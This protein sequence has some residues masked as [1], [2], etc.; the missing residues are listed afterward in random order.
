MIKTKVTVKA[1]DNKT[2][3][4]VDIE[5]NDYADAF[6]LQEVNYLKR[7]KTKFPAFTGTDLEWD[8]ILRTAESIK[9]ENL[10]K[11]KK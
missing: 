6:S 4:S 5:S 8:E 3:I 1:A 11:A 2:Y 7:D 10:G 9:I